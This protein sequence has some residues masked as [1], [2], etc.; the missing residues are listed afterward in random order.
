[1]KNQR[2]KKKTRRDKT[3][4]LVA[5]FMEDEANKDGAPLV[6]WIN[7]KTTPSQLLAAEEQSKHMKKTIDKIL[8]SHY[9][10]Y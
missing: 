4:I 2:R 3:T 8:P 6:V 9:Q 1:M 10:Q 5:Y 7:V